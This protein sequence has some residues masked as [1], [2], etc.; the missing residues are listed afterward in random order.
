MPASIKARLAEPDTSGKRSRQ[1]AS[2]KT[3]FSTRFSSSCRHGPLRPK[4]KLVAE[5]V[6]SHVWQQAIRGDFAA[7]F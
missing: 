7:A 6:Y 1:R 3:S 5:N 2:W 4:K